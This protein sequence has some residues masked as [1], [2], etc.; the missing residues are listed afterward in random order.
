M[1]A[2]FVRVIYDILLTLLSSFLLFWSFF[3]YLES[4]LNFFKLLCWL[5]CFWWVNGWKNP[6]DIESESDG[7]EDWSLLRIWIWLW[8][9]L[10][11][12][13]LETTWNDPDN[14]NM[15]PI[16]SPFAYS[17]KKIWKLTQIDSNWAFFL[18]CLSWRSKNI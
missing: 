5:I 15:N 18:D 1:K 14:M 8:G 9:L 7:I 6:D 11:L 4:F 3:G 16:H 12:G 10:D 2:A 13:G 17:M